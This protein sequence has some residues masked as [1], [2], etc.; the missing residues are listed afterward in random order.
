MVVIVSSV[1]PNIP[2]KIYLKP[3][4]LHYK[5]IQFGW[6]IVTKCYIET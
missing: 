3:D 2:F 5:I 6:Y 1:V 4:D